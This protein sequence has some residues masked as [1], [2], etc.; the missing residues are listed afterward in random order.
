MRL[1]FLE[2]VCR[3]LDF[4]FLHGMQALEMHLL[5]AG[6]GAVGTDLRL[7]DDSSCSSLGRI[8]RISAEWSG[9]QRPKYPIS[10]EK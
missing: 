8:V 6:F 10:Q 3:T 1:K 5:F 4:L 9:Q 7:P 2:Y